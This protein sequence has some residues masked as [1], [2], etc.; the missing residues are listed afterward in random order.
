MAALPNLEVKISDVQQIKEII[1]EANKYKT[2][3][4]NLKSRLHLGIESA[5][6]DGDWDYTI[7]EQILKEMIE[8]EGK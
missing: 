3:W 8:E 6:D 5:K 2:L 1:A 4:D 7:A